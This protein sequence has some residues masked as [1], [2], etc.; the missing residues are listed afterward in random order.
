[1]KRFING[2]IEIKLKVEI[3]G[4]DYVVRK[5][6]KRYGAIDRRGSL[7]DRRSIDDRPDI[8]AT[9][10]RVGDLK[11]DTIIGKRHKQAIVSLVERKSGFTLIKK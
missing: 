10:Q 2:C 3:Y 7:I 6:R 4:S 5:N 1:M 11:A 8:V 9:R